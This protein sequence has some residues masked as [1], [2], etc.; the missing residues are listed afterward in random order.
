[1]VLLDI[2][3][4]EMD[5]YE[6]ARRIRSAPGAAHVLLVAMT[7]YGQD[8]DRRRSQ[9]AG[10]DHHLVKPVEF[11]V[12]LALLARDADRRPGQ[13]PHTAMAPAS[14]SGESGKHIVL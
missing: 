7:G 4:P 9:E 6:V 1:M 10:F 5:G 8:E 11:E 14:S 3:M 13:G 12:V 2:G